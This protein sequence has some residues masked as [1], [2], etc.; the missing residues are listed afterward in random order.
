VRLGQTFTDRAAAT[1]T[2]LRDLT[3]VPPENASLGVAG[4][5]D[6]PGE[7]ALVDEPVGIAISRDGRVAVADTGN[8]R[9]RLLSPFNRLTHLTQ[10]DRDETPSE[11]DRREFRI[12]LV[13]SSYV[14]WN[15]SWHESLAGATEDAIAAA[16]HGKRKP[17][18]YPVM[19]I[20]ICTP[21]ALDLIDEE[22]STGI[23]DMVVLDLST[24]GQMGGEG[25]DCYAGNWQAA[26]KD[27]LV[28]TMANL[29]AANVSLLLVNFPGP[30][31]FPDEFAY[32]RLPKGQWAYIAR[33]NDLTHIQYYHDAIAQ[34]LRDTGAP[35]L[36]LWP[37]F[38]N[39]YESP[40]RVPLFE[41]W[42]HHLSTFGRK[43]VT[44]ALAKRLLTTKGLRA[45]EP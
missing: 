36:D 5:R 38:L 11:V 35:T 39:A 21:Y 17:R 20:G 31:D 3:A 15:Q 13:G 45:T 29:K 16:P 25:G 2:Y 4:F 9:I 1:Y 41:V 22:F 28:K 43:L 40:N 34:I 7:H 6:G 37:A 18:V 42:D 32:A 26:L 30:T 12:A 19:R 8:R 14:W 10:D 33:Q 44:T 27:H 23:F 24:F